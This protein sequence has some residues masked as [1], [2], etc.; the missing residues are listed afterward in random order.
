MQTS[1]KIN[2]FQTYSMIFNRAYPSPARTWV[3]D[4]FFYLLIRKIRTVVIAKDQLLMGI[5][6][7]NH[8]NRIKRIMKK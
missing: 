8:A 6:T 1:V 7:H 4:E 5:S 3:W 2:T